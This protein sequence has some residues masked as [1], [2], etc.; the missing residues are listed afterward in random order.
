MTARRDP[1]L[2][3]DVDRFGIFVP[4]I[5]S[6][7]LL[8]SV[9]T[10]LRDA[11]HSRRHRHRDR[12]LHIAAAAI[13]DHVAT[14]REASAS[15]DQALRPRIAYLV[16]SLTCL[17]VAVYV[18]I[19]A[20][21]NYGK[22]G[23]Y[24]SDIAWLLALSLLSGLLLL[25]LAVGSGLL[26]AR[27]PETPAWAAE[28]LLSTPL[29]QAPER[30]EPTTLR[31]FLLGWA[32]IISAGVFGVV[33]LGV[34]SARAAFQAADERVLGAVDDWTWLEHFE[35]PNL[36]G[37]SEVVLA[38]ALVI[39]VATLR[40]V[41]FAAAYLASV[42][43]TFGVS[44]VTRM[45][46]DRDRPPGTTLTGFEDSYPSGHVAQVVLL[47][48]LLPLAVRVLTNR[49]LVAWPVGLV[50]GVGAVLAAL[51]RVH[52][53]LHWPTDVL[54][55]IALGATMV[56]VVRWV[57]E[58]PAWHQRCH[59]CPWEP[60]PGPEHTVVHLQEWVHG[61]LRLLSMTWAL[62]AIGFF[63]V[64]TA[65]E[66]VPRDPDGESVGELVERYGTYASLTVLGLAWLLALRW[67]GAGAFGL[68][69][70]GLVLGALSS[71]AYHPVI[72]LLVAG[73]FGLP[74]VG[75]WLGWQHR[76]SRRTMIVLASVTVVLATG[77]Y[78]TAANVN[79]RFFGPAHPASDTPALVVDR[80]S[81]AWSG[82]VRT[83]G[84]EVVAEVHDEGDT[85]AV[86]AL[87][88]D[89]DV[90]AR[91][92]RVDVPDSDVVR[93]SV[94]GLDPGTRYEY[95]V[96]V[97]GDRD[98]SRGRG[99]LTTATTGPT[100]LRIAVASCARTGSS[101]QVYDAIRRLAP[102]LYVIS[103]DAHYGNPGTADPDLYRTLL[104]RV[105]TAPAQAA[106]YRDVPV[107]YVWDDHDY[108]PNDA[109]ST[110]P[111]RETAWAAYRE[112]VPSFA[113]STG[114]INQ[115]FSL[116]RVRIVM[117]DTRSA[118]TGSTMLGEQQLAWLLDEL[119]DAARTHALVLWVQ[120]V[121]W[122]APADP[123]RD[124]WGAYDA[125]R[126]RILDV[127]HEDG[128]DNLVMVS[129]DA[130]MV[131]LDDGTNSGGFPVLHAAALD[132]PGNVKGGPYSEGAYPGPGQFGLVEV[133]DDGRDRIEVTLSGRTWEDEVLVSR[134]FDFVVPHAARR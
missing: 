29:G 83:D 77:V 2:D 124:D 110:S 34:A 42:L 28:L 108:G 88:A 103:G 105:L 102:D 125:E 72:S 15:L 4:A 98:D 25:W 8:F 109:D 43:V 81:W 18:V 56:L 89:G 134:T 50:A 31:R 53:A 57:L 65:T 20:I 74:A 6:A 84:F 41:P 24:V 71:V 49:R 79:D 33:T 70:G 40:C 35:L 122:I 46:V 99:H 130:H 101:G 19:G 121:P 3:A 22:P 100:D 36:L 76:R 12:R 44:T 16:T 104:G 75:L 92:E 7:G 127:I 55:G 86:V 45:V 120:S 32:A 69:I 60:T 39:G 95:A 61:P 9:V 58:T 64:L 80:V 128:I 38:L 85:A 96:E 21:G 1:W 107:A 52:H 48:G 106:L 91:S 67:P 66:G 114:P 90:A 94:D 97:D 117:T 118:K 63:A 23:G 13:A 10:L 27:F 11:L 5:M 14:G 59:H 123:A 68:A 30:D 116:G 111:T 119:R 129:G 51:L 62:I 73:A 93:L 82:A 54:G 133:D 87:D 132:R 131:A 17:F 47:A 115:A 78:A 112:L 26:F 37:R 113:A 126:Q